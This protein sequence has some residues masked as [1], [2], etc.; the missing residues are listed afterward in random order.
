MIGRGWYRR[1]ACRVDEAGNVALLVA[2][3]A[4]VLF[5]LIG[6]AVD[7][8]TWTL[9]LATLQRAAD[10]AALAVV[11][12]M[13]VTGA[14]ARRMQSLA[15][16]Y[17][18]GG[19]KLRFGDGPVAVATKPVTRERPGGPFVEAGGR[20]GRA[21]TGVTVT[22]T[23]R[24]SAIMS[25]LVTPHLTDM[26]VTATAE[27]VGGARL[28]VVGLAPSGR[29]GIHLEDQARIEAGDCA[30]YAMSSSP[31]SLEGGDQSVVSAATTCTVGGYAGRSFNFRPQP[32]TGCPTLKD[33]LAARPAPP[34]GPC[35]KRDLVL[36]DGAFTLEPGT[37]CGGIRIEETAD[38]KML[39]GIYVIKDGALVV[40]PDTDLIFLTTDCL[41]PRDESTKQACHKALSIH[42]IGSLK[43]DGVGFYF[44]GEVPRN[45]A[46][47]TQPMV[48][49]PR[50]IVELTAPR[51]GDMAGLLF[52]EDRRSPDGRNFDILSDGARRLVG[53]VYLPRG[54]FSVRAMQ[55]VADQSEYTAIVAHRIALSR[56]PR[57]VVNARYGDTDV[58]VPPGIG[59]KSGQVG[60]AR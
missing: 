53:T 35:L 2:L 29:H 42:L 10:A 5:G 38:V 1:S 46:G 26:T 19:V 8:G 33:P 47:G 59:P 54:T 30:V 13:Q 31:S 52:F 34:V 6:V 27:A 17:M 23:Q 32:I 55:V 24:K 43:G 50:S 49:L 36:R 40:G 22:L 58:P 14:D 16:A 18:K 21:P 20:T 15:E 3:L 12:D 60:L 11:S 57:L 41:H 56:Q 25:R 39:P 45:K 28:C 7:Y 48:F 4:P 9:Q 51:T 44:T 37:Y